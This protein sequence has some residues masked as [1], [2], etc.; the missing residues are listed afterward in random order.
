MKVDS[1]SIRASPFSKH[2]SKS[3]SEAPK[4]QHLFFF[5]GIFWGITTKNTSF[6]KGPKSKITNLHFYFISAK[7]ETIDI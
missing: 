7:M 6:I 2:Y 1:Y 4:L 5:Q 3:F